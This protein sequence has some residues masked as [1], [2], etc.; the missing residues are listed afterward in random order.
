MALALADSTLPF[1]YVVIVAES[2]RMDAM[3]VGGNSDNSG[4]AEERILARIL[5]PFAKR[6]TED[7]EGGC[8]P[9]EAGVGTVGAGGLLVLYGARMLKAVV[10]ARRRRLI[11]RSSLHE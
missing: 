8:G 7:E 4:G 3:G 1:I 6:E 5:N 10:T 2:N 9:A 11:L